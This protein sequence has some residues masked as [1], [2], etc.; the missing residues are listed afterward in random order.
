MRRPPRKPDPLTEAVRK[1]ERRAAEARESGERSGWQN[2]A[3][4][5]TLAWQVLLPTLLGILLGR[6]LDRLTGHPVLFSA[7]GIIGGV[8]LGFWMAFYLWG[9][10]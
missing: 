2:L 10:K 9:R 5:G 4:I 8:A 3:V 7:L 1:R 6:W